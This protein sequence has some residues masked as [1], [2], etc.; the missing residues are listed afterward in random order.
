MMEQQAL[1]HLLT[2]LRR[3]LQESD[4]FSGQVDVTLDADSFTADL[5]P[6]RFSPLKP[7]PVARVV[8]IDGSSYRALDGLSFMVSVSR[9]AAVLANQDEVLETTLSDARTTALSR[10]NVGHIFIDA[11]H[12]LCD[13]EPT[14]IPDTVE[15]VAGALRSLQEQSMARDVIEQLEEVDLCLLDGALHGNRWMQPVVDDTCRLAAERHVHLAAVSKRSDLT[16]RGMP[17]LYWVKRHGNQAMP[18]QRW[19]YPLCEERGIYIARLHPAAPHVFRV[20]VNPYDDTGEQLLSWLA[21]LSDDVTPLGYPYPLAAA[22]RSVVITR[23]EAFYWR[24]RLCEQALHEG[25]S[26]DAWEGLFYDYHTY[27]E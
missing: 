20:D 21:A 26:R 17:L 24:Q 19:Q 18:G 3:I 15:D 4:S 10:D 14:A 9:A 12:G 5:S 11:F 27:L 1:Q 22:H 8:A 7:A 2:T 16:A 6:G 13:A 23:D 25:F